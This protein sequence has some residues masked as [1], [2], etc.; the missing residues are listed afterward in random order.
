MISFTAA[1]FFGCNEN[2]KLEEP[3]YFE[4]KFQSEK[5]GNSTCA[6]AEA[7][8]Y[9]R[10]TRTD[11][12]RISDVDKPAMEAVVQR[13]INDDNCDHGYEQNQAQAELNRSFE[14]SYELYLGYVRIP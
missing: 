12:L 6:K 3:D 11:S 13:W 2:G 4:F 8:L 9:F 7:W 14:G 5:Y 10:I 1:G